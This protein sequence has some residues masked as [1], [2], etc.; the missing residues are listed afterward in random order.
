MALFISACS[1]ESQ[2]DTVLKR[3]ELIVVTSLGPTTFHNRSGN[4]GGFEF[5]LVTLFAQSL[6]VKA[7]FIVSNNFDSVF[8]ELQAEQADFIAAGLSIT[9]QRKKNFLFTPAYHQVKQ[10]LIYHHRT[11]RP[12]SIDKISGLF[13]E[14]VANT[15]HVENLTELNKQYPDLTWSASKDSS[16]SELL[17]MVNSGLL[18]YTVADSNQFE[19]LRG[20]YPKLSAAFD[21]SRPQDI[22]WAFAKTEDLSLY[23][24]AVAFLQSIQDDGTLLQLQDKYFGYSKALDYV[25]L[26][27]YKR[28]IKDRLPSLLPYFRMA[29]IRYGLDWK[30]LA[31][32]AYQESHWNKDAVSP[33]GVRGIMMLTQAT[34]KQIGIE[35]RLDPQQSIIGGARYLSTRLLNIP[36]RIQEPDRTWMAM[37]AYNIGFGHLEDARIL[38]QKQGANP[39]RWVDVKEYLPLL[40]KKEWYKKTKHGYARGN[41]PVVYVRNIRH[42]YDIL[43][44]LIPE[45]NNTN[46][47]TDKALNITLP[48]L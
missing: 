25:G 45:P 31:A 42:Y 1:K 47:T 27:T 41:E 40:R 7:R 10:Q 23:N 14:V 3:G 11:R 33:T 29:A 48:A 17:E 21:I 22:A 5:E 12:R 32:I 8:S 39:D 30:L 15:S 24:K 19:L 4:E 26:C 46:Q 20:Q 44:R 34:A 9:S 6:G 38:T 36:P 18:D 13:F 16:V 43:Q 2:L 28:H 35:N 37:A